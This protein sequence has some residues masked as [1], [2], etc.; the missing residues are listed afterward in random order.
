VTFNYEFVKL[1]HLLDD[2]EIAEVVR[3]SIEVLIIFH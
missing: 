1:A 3:V 2:K